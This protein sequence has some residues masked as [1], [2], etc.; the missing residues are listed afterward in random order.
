[1]LLNHK[2]IS[3]TNRQSAE[4]CYHIQMIKSSTSVTKYMPQTWAGHEGSNINTVAEYLAYKYTKIWVNWKF[5]TWKKTYICQ[6]M[7]KDFFFWKTTSL[8]IDWTDILFNNT[9]RGDCFSSKGQLFKKWTFV[10]TNDK[11]F[12]SFHYSIA[13]SPP[14][15]P[16]GRSN[17][18]I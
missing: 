4:K 12:P 3:G 6:S 15:I 7:K 17:C 9:W 14:Y 5:N 1:M 10:Y 2:H 8:Y 13:L 11:E 18:H 16:K